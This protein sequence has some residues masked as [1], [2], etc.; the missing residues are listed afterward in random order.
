[1]ALKDSADNV[2]DTDPIVFDGADDGVR[3][4]AIPAYFDLDADGTPDRIS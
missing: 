2:A 3:L 1:M 4:G